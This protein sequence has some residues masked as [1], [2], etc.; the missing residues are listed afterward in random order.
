M[1]L[2]R[3]TSLASRNDIHGYSVSPVRCA[4]TRSWSPA[5]M[6]K[7]QAKTEAKHESWERQGCRFHQ[8]LGAWRGFNGYDTSMLQARMVADMSAVWLAFPFVT[9]GKCGNECL[10]ATQMNHLNV[11]QHS[12][13]AIRATVAGSPCIL[14]V[15]IRELKMLSHFATVPAEFVNEYVANH[16]ESSVLTRGKK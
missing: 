2:Q 5:W 6:G 10:T 12:P 9:S 1:Q 15:S 11:T 3:C 16:S 4:D 13:V 8:V 14:R 7:R